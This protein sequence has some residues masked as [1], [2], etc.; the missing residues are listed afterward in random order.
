MMEVVSGTG[1]QTRDAAGAAKYS[2]PSNTFYGVGFTLTGNDFIFQIVEA[3][4]DEEICSNCSYIQPILDDHY[5]AAYALNT[6]SGTA[7]SWTCTGTLGGC[8]DYG[9]VAAVAFKE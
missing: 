8:P 9:V 6:S 2:D 5:G 7:P 1:N 4:S 3:G